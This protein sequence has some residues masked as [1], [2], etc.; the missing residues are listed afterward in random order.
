MEF[1]QNKKLLFLPKEAFD[2]I[3]S[4]R[5]MI[6]DVLKYQRKNNSQVAELILCL[7]IRFIF[8]ENPKYH[9]N[10]K[11]LKPA[12]LI[13]KYFNISRAKIMGVINFGYS[14]GNT[15]YTLVNLDIPYYLFLNIT[16]LM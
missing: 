11:Y 10:L 4:H 14:D 16:V 13:G 5:E 3:V 12:V 6:I 7:V 15:F 1:K 8:G 9:K 2:T